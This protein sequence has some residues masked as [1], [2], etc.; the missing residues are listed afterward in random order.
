MRFHHTV[1]HWMAYGPGLSQQ[2]ITS[3]A[4]YSGAT[5][6]AIDSRTYAGFTISD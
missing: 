2:A 5:P 4:F 6:R 1:I 3:A